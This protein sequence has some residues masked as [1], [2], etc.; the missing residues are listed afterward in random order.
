M[1]STTQPCSIRSAHETR[2]CAAA[3][4]Q[5]GRQIGQ[6]RTSGQDGEEET[7]ADFRQ[8]VVRQ[9]A[10][11]L[12]TESALESMSGVTRQVRH[13]GQPITA[14]QPGARAKTKAAMQS[15]LAQVSSFAVKS[16]DVKL[17]D[18]RSPSS[19]ILNSEGKSLHSF[20]YHTP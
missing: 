20:A 4:R 19:E 9:L 16:F 3:V 14:S 1:K 8:R 10:A 18:L 7:R 15:V 2:F 5:R 17:C 12:P 6:Q 11:Y 13:T